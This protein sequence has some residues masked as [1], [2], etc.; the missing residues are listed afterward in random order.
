MCRHLA[1]MGKKNS[2]YK[3]LLNKKHSLV[4]M[5]FKP[6][7]MENAKLNA[8]GFGIAWELNSDLFLY[9]NTF[10]IWN[11]ANLLSLTK[12]ISSNLVIANVRSATN[13]YDISYNNTHP[14]RYK[15][16]IFSHNG[17]IKDFNNF[18][19]KKIIEYIDNSLLMKIRGDTD[20]EYIFFLFIHIFNEL[21]NVVKAI[22]MTFEFLKAN[23]KQ[24]ML[25][26]LLAQI[27]D[28]KTN[29]FA[30]RYAIKEESPSLYFNL[31]N[32]K[33][34]YICSERMDDNKWIKV[35]NSSLLK[36]KDY[37]LDIY[38]L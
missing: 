24:A 32:K 22:K 13:A 5:A 33:D 23:C 36:Y 21:N 18:C 14:F 17:Y 9:K 11:D 2:L 30:T 20:S 31:Q 4:D 3:L 27:S 7:E 35:K 15:N 1:Y 10:P 34:I 8:D 28:N 26:F 29:L 12:N 38:S 6:K 37:S 25:N 16:F 19:K